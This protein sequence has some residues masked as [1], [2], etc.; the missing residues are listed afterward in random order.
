MTFFIETVARSMVIINWLR[1]SQ[2]VTMNG[3]VEIK[4]KLRL[5]KIYIENATS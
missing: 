1:D 5:L 3:A 2:P 4:G